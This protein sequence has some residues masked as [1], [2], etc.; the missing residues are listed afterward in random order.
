MQL[1]LFVFEFTLQAPAEAVV[2]RYPHGG[3]ADPVRLRYDPGSNRRLIYPRLLVSALSAAACASLKIANCPCHDG[4][5]RRAATVP[6]DIGL[7]E[8]P[9]EKFVARVCTR[10]AAV[11]LSVILPVLNEA[12]DIAATL[13]RL[14][15][16]DESIVVDAG[17]TDGTTE[18]SNQL[19]SRVICGPRGR[20]RQMNEGARAAG[21]EVLLFL[22][23]DT[24]LP[25]GACSLIREAAESSGFVWGYF[26]VSIAGRSHWL[27]IVAFLMNRRSRL[28]HVATGDQAI[29][30][31]R[32][33]FDT[34]RGFP[35]IPIME[36]VALS[37]TLRR[38]GRPVCLRARVV[39]SGRRWDA[40]GALRTIATMWLMR[41][42]YWLGVA[43]SRL[44]RLYATL[45][46]R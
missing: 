41:L 39:T 30:M 1:A 5:A 7:Y 46:R 4:A 35:E 25:P 32:R 43:P 33:A 16:F 38:Q 37:K 19:A 3:V 24:V 22:H 13:A 20:A 12:N 6:F 18:I 44:A 31:S 11:R 14:E 8:L 17:S 34:A 2:P 9:E 28:T 21:G 10:T 45:R 15:E 27:P 36:D 29:F 42:G 40:N 26:G 23:A